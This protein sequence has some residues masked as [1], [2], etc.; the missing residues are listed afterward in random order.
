MAFSRSARTVCCG[1]TILRKL[2]ISCFACR[3][4]A[5][6]LVGATLEDVVLDPLEL[7]ADLPEHRERRV[8]AA[9]D[10]L[11]EEVPGA[12]RE[13]LVAEVLAGLVALEDGPQR[14]E[15]LV[16]EGD[17]EVGP[18]EHVD[19][20]RE[21]PAGRL[22]EAR[23][24]QNDEQVLVV[25]VE[26]RALVARE[27]VLEVERVEPELRLEPGL[28]VE[29]RALDVDPAQPGRLD[30][31]DPRRPPGTASSASR[32]ACERRRRVGRGRLGID[33]LGWLH[34]F[35]ERPPSARPGRRRRGPSRGARPHL[36]TAY[37]SVLCR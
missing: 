11:V 21:Q 32:S 3:D 7:E 29:V 17:E 13:R 9:V 26:L 24:L 16:R 22:V 1:R 12:L 6:D 30:D 15:R 34:S 33:H 5:H 35:Y 25:G 23:E 18:D 4:V 27:D 37:R 10:E 28:V 31:L 14:D 19:L 20:G 8:D 2:M 36:T